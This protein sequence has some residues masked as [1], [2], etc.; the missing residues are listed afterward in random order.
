MSSTTRNAA[1]RSPSRLGRVAAV[2]A[3]VT[4]AAVI[5]GIAANGPAAAPARPAPPRA[6]AAARATAA[7]ALAGSGRAVTESRGNASAKIAAV[8][9]VLTAVDRRRCPA[10]AS[11]C[12]DL[13]RHFTWLQYDGRVNYGPVRMEP[14][15]PG[16]QHQT[17]R[18]TFIVS[19]K[20]GPSYVSSTYREAMPWATF[21]GTGGDAF[22]GGSLTSWS[23]GC[24]HLTDANAH[25]FNEHLPV[26]AQ[27]VVF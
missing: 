7:P 4:A 22:H 1:L 8:P 3:A 2:T 21:F 27:V 16:G 14:G 24:V 23:H 19:W 18:G 6:T 26:G 20:A 9:L 17:P 13:T 5:A 12:V 25:Y 15:R 11:A 10:T